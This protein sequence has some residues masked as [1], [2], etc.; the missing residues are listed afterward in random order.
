MEY[1]FTK[2]EKRII[3]GA[4]YARKQDYE[5]WEEEARKNPGFGI[6]AKKWGELAEEVA[7]VIHSVF[8]NLQAK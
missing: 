1:V 7:S 5:L 3:L 4:L 2:N 8:V 6:T